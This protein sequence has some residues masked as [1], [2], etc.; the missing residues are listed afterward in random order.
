VTRL[1]YPKQGRRHAHRDLL[2]ADPGSRTVTAIAY[3]WGFSNASRFA[4]W[5]QEAYGV[6]PSH[7]VHQDQPGQSLDHGKA[8]QG[9]GRRAGTGPVT[10]SQVAAGG[11]LRASGSR[12]RGGRCR[13]GA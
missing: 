8:R 2:A 5:Y 12:V 10:N 13:S 7:T 6:R 11:W 9:R 1:R 4:T 3:R